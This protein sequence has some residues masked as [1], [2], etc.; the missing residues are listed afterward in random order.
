MIDVDTS[1]HASRV[2][3]RANLREIASW[4]SPGGGVTGR[5]ERGLARQ[6]ELGGP[7]PVRTAACDALADI[8][9][10]LS[11][12]AVEFAH[13]DIHARPGL[14]AARRELVVLGVLIAPGGQEAQLEAHLGAALNAGLRPAELVEA[15]M[16]VLPYAGFPG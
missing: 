1:V 12:L 3:P 5:Y 10:D 2:T 8:A 11:R 13:G 14:D 9:P 16:Q 7:G 15:I 6:A 4:R